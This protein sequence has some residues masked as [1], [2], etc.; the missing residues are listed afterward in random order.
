MACNTGYVTDEEALVYQ[1]AL[2]S[3]VA[4]TPNLQDGSTVYPKKRRTKSPLP[5]FDNPGHSPD[6]CP[7][8]SLGMTV[9]S[10]IKKL[11][12]SNC[13]S[14]VKLETSLNKLEARSTVLEQHRIDGTIPK[15][16]LLPKKMAF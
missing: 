12:V 9:G 1:G 13:R 7:A 8:P 10:E 4:E 16:L 6:H 15:D 2:V 14:I 11:I 5:P 3:A